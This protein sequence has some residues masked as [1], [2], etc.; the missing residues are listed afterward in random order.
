MTQLNSPGQVG[1]VGATFNHPILWVQDAIAASKLSI[2]FD[3]REYQEISHPDAATQTEH[4]VHEDAQTPEHIIKLIGWKLQQSKIEPNIHSTKLPIESLATSSRAAKEFVSQIIEFSLPFSE[5]CDRNDQTSLSINQACD[6]AKVAISHLR[7]PQKSIEILSLGKRCNQS[8]WD[9]GNLIKK[10]EQDIGNSIISIQPDEDDRLRLAILE[11]SQ[12]QDRFAYVRKRGQV[13]SH[14]RLSKSEVEDLI[15]ETQKK[16]TT[17]TLTSI[18]FDELLD[19]EIQELEWL[20]PELLPAGEMVILGGSPKSGKTLMAVDAAFA[21]ATGED[22]FLGLRPQQ[23][24][25]LLISNDENQ[26]STKSK[27]LKRGFRKGDNLQIIFDWNISR[28]YE[29]ERVLDNFRPDVVIIDSLKSIT[30]HNSQISENSAEFAN[31]LY[32]LKN[33]FNRY[34]TSSILIHHT[35]KNKDAMGVNKLRGSTAIA[36]AVWG[37]WQLEQIPSPDP[38]NP[39]KIIIDPSDPRRSLA[40]HARD[41][42]GQIL[43]IEFDPENNSYTRTDKE[44]LKEQ[45]TLCDRILGVLRINRSG[46]TGRSI[47]ECLGMDTEQGRGVYTILNRMESKKLIST[48]KSTTDRRVTLYTTKDSQHA[49]VTDCKLLNTKGDSLPPPVC[50]DEIVK[51]AESTTAYELKNTQQQNQNTQQLTEN[52]Q[53]LFD[54]DTTD[55]YLNRAP[56]KSY[57]DTQQLFDEGGGGSVNQLTVSKSTELPDLPTPNLF[58]TTSDL[59]VDQVVRFN[60]SAANPSSAARVPEN[61]GVGVVVEIGLSVIKVRW[62]G[63]VVP[64]WHKPTDLLF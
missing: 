12:E 51:I 35:N 62:N 26:R 40:V 48:I 10:L 56:S 23:G 44:I 19:I 47:I 3:V 64:Q 43:S 39:G 30:S 1:A 49:N 4:Y 7:D 16:T 6:V 13:C 32:L 9:W 21:I 50:V 60:R 54:T 15:Q 42:E 18:T 5:W 45:A 33:L 29:L 27:L 58:A 22:D 28:L 14:F 24:K 11:L 36:G 17:N 52:T 57:A 25:V 20:I 38:D 37:T 2:L 31:S 8:S 53:Q 41:V 55:D 46:L 59:Q 34:H 61:C 63:L